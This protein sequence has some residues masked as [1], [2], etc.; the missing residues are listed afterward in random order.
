M[1]KVFGKTEGEFSSLYYSHLLLRNQI[2][3][4]SEISRTELVINL[5]NKYILS[6]HIL[7]YCFR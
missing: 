7:R 1:G 2:F 6:T 4:D 3:F 5:F